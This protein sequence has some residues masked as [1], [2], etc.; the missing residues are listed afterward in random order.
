[1]LPNV[2]NFGGDQSQGKTLMARSLV[3]VLA[4]TFASPALAGSSMSRSGYA[5][6]YY[7]C[8]NGEPMN[9]L[10]RHRDRTFTEFS[11]TPGQAL[12]TFVQQGDLVATRCDS[13]S[14]PLTLNRFT[15]V[16]TMP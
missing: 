6:W 13:R 2:T 4:C 8:A 14:V 11:L 9:I 7:A 10:I 1:M 5:N 3:I 16:V 15:Y 12:R